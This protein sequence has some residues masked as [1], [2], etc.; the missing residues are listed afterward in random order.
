MKS[1]RSSSKWICGKIVRQSVLP[2]IGLT[3]IQ[4]MLNEMSPKFQLR[5]AKWLKSSAT[6]LI[7]YGKM[8]ILANYV[9]MCI[10]IY[11]YVAG[12]LLCNQSW[13]GY[14]AFHHL[15]KITTA[16][17]TGWASRGFINMSLNCFTTS[18][19]CGVLITLCR[20]LIRPIC[21]GKCPNCWYS[22]PLVR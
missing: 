7:A 22:Q 12:D 4:P 21:A 11:V 16:S 5:Q 2:Q 6:R 1:Q 9:Y 13:L 14:S 15:V 19:W 17:N 18:I 8:R 10:Y 20:V 3:K